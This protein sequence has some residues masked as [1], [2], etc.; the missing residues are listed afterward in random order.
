MV[1]HL[2]SF[3]A[4]PLLL[5]LIV[6][7]AM[8]DESQFA[9]RNAAEALNFH[10]SVILYSLVCVPLMLIGVGIVLVVILWLLS[11]VC[12]AVA[13]I[14]ASKGTCYRYPLTIRLIG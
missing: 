2:S 8:K 11:L 4:A 10:L 14:K 5:P 13:A 7:L 3:F 9:S 12:S 1:C 6:Y